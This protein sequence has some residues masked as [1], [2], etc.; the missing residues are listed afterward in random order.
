M[1][2]LISQAYDALYKLELSTGYSTGTQTRE[3]IVAGNSVY[4]ELLTDF[5][6]TVESLFDRIKKHDS[7][8]NVAELNRIRIFAALLGQE[9]TCL[10]VSISEVTNAIEQEAMDRARALYMRQQEQAT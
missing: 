8:V 6:L 9:F 7:E 5:N 4:E 3:A 2:I 1:K 10:A